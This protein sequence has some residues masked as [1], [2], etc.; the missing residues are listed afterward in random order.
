[1]AHWLITGVSSGFGLELARAALARG[2]TVAG[3]VRQSGQA[4]SFEQ[5]APG[6]AHSVLLGSVSSGVAHHAT[7]PVVIVRHVHEAA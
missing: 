2:D 7:C 1:M 3:T 6:R 4:D 5:L